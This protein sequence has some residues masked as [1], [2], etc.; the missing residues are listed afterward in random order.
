M[1]IQKTKKSALQVLE[2]GWFELH[3]N[4]PSHLL[5][6]FNKNILNHKKSPMQDFVTRT[7]AGNKNMSCVRP[8]LINP[9]ILCL[10]DT[11][12]HCTCYIC[13]LGCAQRNLSSFE[14]KFD[15]TSIRLA[16]LIFFCCFL[17]L[18]TSGRNFF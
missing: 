16:R 5:P 4:M 14:F 10:L 17:T 2:L 18:P 12:V 8:R 3:D 1:L 15:D 13:R 11:Y 9:K 6:F 7:L